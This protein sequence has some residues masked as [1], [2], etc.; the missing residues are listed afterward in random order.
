[1]V[2]ADE[3]G[4]VGMSRTFWKGLCD[5]ALPL[6]RAL[7]ALRASDTGVTEKQDSIDF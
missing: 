1:M 2:G 3:M 4:E 5:R 6:F 7:R